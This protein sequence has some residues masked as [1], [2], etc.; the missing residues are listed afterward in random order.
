MRT[1]P[2]STKG[3]ELASGLGAIVLGAGLALLLPQWLR[4]YAVPLLVGG[5]VV[6]AAG[7][8]LKYRIEVRNG[9]RLL[10]ER[11][12]FWLCWAGLAGLGIWIATAA[13]GSPPS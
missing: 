12:Q 7:M 11:A 8:T 9:P 1:R 3:A 10:W 6:H 5:A 4:A 13:W 2:A